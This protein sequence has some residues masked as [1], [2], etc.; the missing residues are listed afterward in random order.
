MCTSKGLMTWPSA[1]GSVMTGGVVARGGIPPVTR[2]GGGNKKKRREESPQ[3]HGLEATGD[4]A[5]FKKRA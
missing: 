3:G 5:G 4:L 2:P 1:A